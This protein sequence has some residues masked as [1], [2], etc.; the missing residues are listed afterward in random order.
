MR[1]GKKRVAGCA[2]VFASEPIMA[3]WRLRNA[4]DFRYPLTLRAQALRI[5][6]RLS[7]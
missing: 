7:A 3:T 6:A 2:S 4:V 5:F 1:T